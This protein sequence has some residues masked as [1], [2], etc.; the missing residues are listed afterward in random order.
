VNILLVSVIVLPFSAL[1]L[2]VG[3]QERHP[4]CENLSEVLASLSVW[5]EMQMTCIW[6]SY[7]HCHLSSLASVKSRWLIFL[8]PL[9]QVVLEKKVK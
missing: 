3:R 2:L 7:Y 8:V 6:Y 1:P 5:S 4:A 9:T